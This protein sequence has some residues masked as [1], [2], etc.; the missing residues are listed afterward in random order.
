MQSAVAA[1]VQDTRRTSKAAARGCLAGRGVCAE[2]RSLASSASPCAALPMAG[3]GWDPGP[4]DGGGTLAPWPRP[5]GAFNFGGA[6][7]AAAGRGWPGRSTR[8]A[9]S[10][11][12][13]RACRS[14]GP[15]RPPAPLPTGCTAMTTN[16]LLYLVRKYPADNKCVAPTARPGQSANG[17]PAT[18]LTPHPKECS[19]PED[20]VPPRKRDS[21]NERKSAT[22]T[23]PAPEF[24][25][26]LP[27]LPP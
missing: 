25:A 8:A 15:N 21:G 2:R 13:A 17:P 26:T 23:R 3:G 20:D 14:A 1:D 16:I 6:R 7:P 12:R 18:F 4:W 22:A 27:A 10:S 11:T 9:A 19:T 24:M 5:G